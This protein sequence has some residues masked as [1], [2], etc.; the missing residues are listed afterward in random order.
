[1]L[2]T[3]AFVVLGV[4]SSIINIID[5]AKEVYK[6]VSD[7]TG[8]P[9]AFREVAVRLLVVPS[10]LA[11]AQQSFDSSNTDGNSLEVKGVR[12]AV[13]ACQKKARKLEMLFKAMMPEDGAP[14]SKRYLSAI[15]IL[16]EGSR[17]ETLMKETH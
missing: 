4:I 12:G 15:R 1:M 6:A 13:G 8:L 16:T 9:K 5:S 2:G 17:V 10:I 3:E 14:R 11:S 7:A